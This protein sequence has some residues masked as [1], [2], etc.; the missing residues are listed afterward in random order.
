VP[1]GGG[2]RR[3]RTEILRVA[4]QR[5]LEEGHRFAELLLAEEGHPEHPGIVG[6]RQ[7]RRVAAE[8]VGGFDPLHRLART[9][10]IDHLLGHHHC[11]LRVALLKLDPEPGKS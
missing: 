10:A 6:R 9:A 8:P 3:G 1:V 5:V 7:P 2:E 11:A 4:G